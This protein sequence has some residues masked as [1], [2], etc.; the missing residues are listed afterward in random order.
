MNRHLLSCALLASLLWSLVWTAPPVHAD[1][2]AAVT[3]YVRP[4]GGSPTQCTGRVDAP[5][6][7]SGTNQPCAW[8]HP[9]RA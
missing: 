4:D 2:L 9:F 6:P 7:G 3:Y 8:D 1:S 5:Y